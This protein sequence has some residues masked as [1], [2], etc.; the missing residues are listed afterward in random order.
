MPD[1]DHQGTQRGYD[2]RL[3]RQAEKDLK[4][5]RAYMDKVSKALL[6]LETD[7]YAG[8]TLSGSLRGVRALEFS[9]PGG[10]NRAAYCVMVDDHACVVFAIGPHENYYK[11]AERRYEALLKSGELDRPLDRGRQ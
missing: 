5:L 6:R 2:V 1:D 4:A 8:H 7:P 10:A 9:L 3:T 11:M